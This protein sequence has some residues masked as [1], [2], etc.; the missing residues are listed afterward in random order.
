MSGLLTGITSAIIFNPI[1][2]ANYLS[3]IQNL[4]ITNPYIWKNCFNRVER[5]FAGWAY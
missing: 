1:D 3:T 2:K 5:S 4:K